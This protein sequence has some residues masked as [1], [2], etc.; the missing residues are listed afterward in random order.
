MFSLFYLMGF[1]SDNR[2]IRLLS[3][4][5]L[6]IA[7]GTKILPALLAVLTLKHRGFKEFG[8]CTIITL[9][10]LFLPGL[11][12]HD[13]SLFEFIKNAFAFD[14]S[15]AEGEILNIRGLTLLLG[16][17]ETGFILVAGAF[18]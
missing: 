13:G 7:A 16:L 9:S 8:L 18:V 10:L 3:Y 4:V 14:A 12:I 11:L 15:I 17:D 2:Y 1:E 5:C 6:G